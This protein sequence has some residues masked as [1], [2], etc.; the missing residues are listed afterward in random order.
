MC[1]TF[2]FF[3]K[4]EKDQSYFAKN[5][6][7]DPGEP[8]IIELIFN[9]KDDFKTNFLLESLPKYTRQLE[10]LK[11]VFPKFDHPYAAI[12]S[13]PTWIWGAE[14]GVNEKGV[15]IG[16]E[17]VFSKEPLIPNGLLGMDILRL[18]LHNAATAEEGAGLITQL[19]ETYG[20]GGNGSYSGTLKYHNSFLVKDIDKAFV[21]ESSGKNWVQKEVNDCASISN[22]YTINKG[23]SRASTAFK[24]IDL[25]KK[26]EHPF[27]TFFSK[28]ELRHKFTRDQI[29]S[30]DKDLGEVFDILR[31][32]IRPGNTLKKGMKSICVHPG[33]IV[34][35][36]TTSSMVVD[37][38]GNHILVWITSAPN[39]CV[40]LFKPIILTK[41]TKAFP[42][43]NDRETSLKYFKSNR[44]LSE[45]LVK[46]QKFF[47][48]D[49]KSVRDSLQQEF[50]DIIY[51]NL[52]NKTEEELISDCRLCYSKE[53][54]YI[55]E[56]NA[57][58][59]V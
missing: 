41:N 13:R 59:K 8:Q 44:E 34:K 48:E 7:R 46:H 51:T 33:T 28:G 29:A 20:Q 40:S 55:E 10:V 56:V 43:F 31:S 30:Q 25:K 19:L 57:L 27:Y 6:D 26:L 11:Q 16:N 14:M 45:H 15:A 9:A 42:E 4:I 58:D 49:I 53:K 32:H 22:C 2:T 23:H 50:I 24:N 37:Y 1:D 35:S 36:E 12:I 38:T 17:A 47:R 18:A 39:P 3:S 5:S 54:E 21:I 52:E